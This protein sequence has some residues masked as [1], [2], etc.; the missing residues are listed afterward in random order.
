MTNLYCAPFSSVATTTSTYNCFIDSVRNYVDRAIAAVTVFTPSVNPTVTQAF[1]PKKSSIASTISAQS[2]VYDNDGVTVF[3]TMERG[4]AVPED[5]INRLNV[6]S[7]I[8]K[9]PYDWNGNRAEQFS[10]E[11]I[12]RCRMLL[13]SFENQPDIFPTAQ[14]SI[15][16]EW[17]TPAGDFLEIEVFEDGSCT[18][19][20]QRSGFECVDRQIDY[21][22]IGDFVAKFFA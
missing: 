11:L 14:D 21:S 18:V 5:L 3:A 8:A 1:N 12:N 20:G 2:C 15:Q 13:M 22:E 9:L 17:E 6:L 7:E 16:F 10:A 19:Y 4:A